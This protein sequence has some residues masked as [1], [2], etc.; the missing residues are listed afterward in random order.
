MPH[1]SSNRNKQFIEKLILEEDKTIKW[2]NPNLIR[3]IPNGSED[4]NY[5]T[6]SNG[7]HGYFWYLHKIT[8]HVN[9]TIVEL[10]NRRGCSTLAI[11]DALKKNQKFYSLDIINDCR[12]VTSDVYDD[13]RVS[14]INDFNSV[15]GDRIKSIFKLK[16][17]GMLFCDTIHTYEQVSTEYN[18]WSP[19]LKDDAIIIVDDIRDNF[20]ASDA[21]T[22]WKFHDEWRGIKYDVTDTAHQSGFGIY[23][24]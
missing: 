14:I 10:G 1:N 20:S 17:I 18:V 23:F 15:D 6:N 5:I 22:K 2:N 4:Y 11:Y 12:Y 24:N 3:L 9:G 8:S 16:S 7:D 13:S 19:Y 21:R